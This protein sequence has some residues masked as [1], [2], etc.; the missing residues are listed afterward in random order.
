MRETF[1]YAV[2][3]GGLAAAF[4][5]LVAP[6]W[7]DLSLVGLAVV[8]GAALLGALAVY[9]VVLKAVAGSHD[10]LRQLP[11]WAIAL[12]SVGAGLPAWV[13]AASGGLA[14]QAAALTAPA[15]GLVCAGIALVSLH[16]RS[17]DTAV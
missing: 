12:I 5:Y 15:L 14:G 16:R 2:L 1:P 3:A 7:L 11:W 8:L 6:G 13:S 17:R 10:E 9:L 4:A